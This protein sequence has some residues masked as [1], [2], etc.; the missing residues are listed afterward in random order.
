MAD[1]SGAVAVSSNL[2][3]AADDESNALRLYRADA[4]GRPV[5]EYDFSQFLE[6]DRKHVEADL[7]AAARIGDRA[8]W[9]GSHGRNKNGRE[10]VNRG[11]FFATDIKL[12]GDTVELT[13][14]GRVYRHLLPDLTSDARFARFHLA[15]AATRAP[16]EAN[17]LNIE[18]LAATPEGHLLI[19]FRNPIPGGKAL[20]IPLLNP[21]E[22]ISGKRPLFGSAIQLDLDGLGIRDIALYQGNYMVIGGPYNGDGKFELFKWNGSDAEPQRIKVKHL[23]QYHPEALIIYPGKGLHEFQVLSDDGTLPVNGV[24]GKLV[25]DPTNKTFRS[26]WVSLPE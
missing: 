5:R 26:F 22:V 11:C 15:E 17:A 9:M 24:P 23:S 2:F 7:E 20:L 25:K 3:I 14:A 21:D 4:P 8:F 13:P 16:K 12:T 10:R 19:G 1:A 6:I 18:G